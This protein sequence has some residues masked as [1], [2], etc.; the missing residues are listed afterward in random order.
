MDTFFVF[1]CDRR[2]RFAL[3]FIVLS[4]LLSFA[5]SGVSVCSDCAQQYATVRAQAVI[6]TNNLENLDSQIQTA[7]YRNQYISSQ[8]ANIRSWYSQS[9]TAIPSSVES[10]CRNAEDYVLQN[11]STLTTLRDSVSSSYSAALSQLSTLDSFN[12]SCSS[13]S[14]GCASI[15]SQILTALTSIKNN[16]D[17]N[18]PLIEESTFLIQDDVS[19]MVSYLRSIYFKAVHKDDDYID[20]LNQIAIGMSII[21]DR[22]LT[23]PSTL[24]NSRFSTDSDRNNLEL[25]IGYLYS[26][27]YQNMCVNQKSSETLNEILSVISN[28]SVSVTNSSSTTGKWEADLAFI[29]NYLYTIQRRYFE[30]FNNDYLFRPGSATPVSNSNQYRSITNSWDVMRD[31]SA[32][33][34]QKQTAYNNLRGYGGI[35]TN[36]FERIEFALYGIAGFWDSNRSWDSSLSRASS[37]T[38]DFSRLIDATNSF[39]LVSSVFSVSNQAQT[40]VSEFK[41]LVDAFDFSSS[42]VPSATLTLCPSF[43][44]GDFEFSGIAFEMYDIHE[45]L[46]AIRTAFQFVWTIGFSFFGIALAAKFFFYLG[47]AIRDVFIL[48]KTLL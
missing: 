48:L 20:D 27:D 24:A 17:D 45:V 19:Y 12:C 26:V 2:L 40:V 16:L 11:N 9:G 18:L 22:P 36:W 6:I 29:S 32:T 28:I 44:I 35:Y 15:L 1:S 42:S 37:V 14:C 7:I 47:K 21:A 5:C 3:Y 33:V 13:N 38:N 25:G 30:T 41:N 46:E 39:S 43:Q 23:F 34:F 8:V 31:S 10:A 4:L